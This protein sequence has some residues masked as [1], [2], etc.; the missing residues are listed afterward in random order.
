MGDQHRDPFSDSVAGDSSSD[1]YDEDEINALQP[2]QAPHRGMNARRFGRPGP[3]QLRRRAISG[4]MRDTTAESTLEAPPVP[5]HR[6]LADRGLVHGSDGSAGPNP[7]S[8]LPRAAMTEKQSHVAASAESPSFGG[9]DADNVGYHQNVHEHWERTAGQPEDYENQ[10]S[11]FPAGPSLGPRMSSHIQ[12]FHR[13][14]PGLVSRPNAGPNFTPT[15]RQSSHFNSSPPTIT[16]RSNNW[17][18]PH[19][20]GF[21][22]ED[23]RSKENFDN[24]SLSTVSAYNKGGVSSDASTPTSLKTCDHSETRSTFFWKGETAPDPSEAATSSLFSRERDINLAHPSSSGTRTASSAQPSDPFMSSESA[25]SEPVHRRTP[26]SQH[27][28]YHE[29]LES[30][31][32]RG[33]TSYGEA[34]H[35]ASQALD[36]GPS[37]YDFSTKRL[38]CL[39]PSS[40]ARDSPKSDFDYA[41]G[42]SVVSGPITQTLTPNTSPFR[43]RMA[44]TDVSQG[45]GNA[46]TKLDSEFAPR[47]SLERWHQLTFCPAIQ[48]RTN[49]RLISESPIHHPRVDSSIISPLKK[50]IGSSH[51][52]HLTLGLD[53]CR[54]FPGVRPNSAGTVSASV[55]ELG[56]SSDSESDSEGLGR[57]AL[58]TTRR[59]HV[60]ETV[61]SNVDP[62]FSD[63]QDRVVCA[64]SESRSSDMIGVAVINVT[65]GQV[66]LIRIV[67]DDRYRRLIETLWKG[68]TW[69]QTFLVLKKVIDQQSKSSLTNCLA[70]EFPK[71][72][73][74]PLDREHWNE[75]EGLRMV[76]RFAWRKSIKAIHRSLEHNFYVSCAFAAVCN[77]LE[78]T[79]TKMLT[80]LHR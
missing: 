36:L 60:D 24:F 41:Y 21:H 43:R 73:V 9:W 2:L 19:P 13:M 79:G 52:Q 37:S 27:H 68:S 3:D 15:R 12:S 26:K 69:P 38:T 25:R 34:H 8:L 11:P 44:P 42:Q 32:T 4:A 1:P 67:N 77:L 29:P 5:L 48:A 23:Q 64:I 65:M 39:G 17:L 53:E 30:M 58:H 57:H 61:N 71:A 45:F 74:V 75:S 20:F 49:N 72:E 35:S 47:N 63:E 40:E 70:K 14:S 33:G 55:L 22:Q 7:A 66:D 78:Q 31:D 18:L 76:D 28:K 6:D 51:P 46:R 50:P 62:D 10:T 16:E 56:L 59:V 54:G 80:L